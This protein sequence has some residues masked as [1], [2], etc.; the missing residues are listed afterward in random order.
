MIKTIGKAIKKLKSAGNDVL[1]LAGVGLVFYGVFLIYQPAAFIVL[2]A[3]LVY[4]AIQLERG[5]P[6]G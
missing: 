4:W 3:G 1:M 6:N 2:G 5:K